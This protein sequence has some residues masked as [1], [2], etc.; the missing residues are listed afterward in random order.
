MVCLLGSWLTDLIRSKQL[1]ATLTI[2]KIN[3]ILGLWV[4]GACGV[5]AVYSGCNAELAVTLFALA[6]GLNLLTVP[7]CKSGFMDIAP[8]YSG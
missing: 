8:D 2:R 6:A 4:T 1:L 3:T 7:G 5:L